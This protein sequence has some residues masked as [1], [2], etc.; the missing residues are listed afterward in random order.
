MKS[1]S[2]FQ[3]GLTAGTLLWLLC[4]GCA[5]TDTTATAAAA[6]T[7]VAVASVAPQG[8][9]PAPAAPQPAISPA[10]PIPSIVSPQVDEGASWAAIK[11][12]TFDQR[13]SF[14]SGAG[15]LESQLS[16]QV[17][18]LNA[19]RAALPSTVDT[20][21]WD[22]AMRDLV[23]SQEYLK[24]MVGEAGQSSPDTWDQEKDKVDQ[25]WQK[26]ED[27]FDKVRTATTF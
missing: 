21:D 8:L 25:A 5:K 22:F 23:V 11:D 26:A 4:A 12:F 19:K 20:K 10:V 27:A 13:A 6:P 24:S 18:Q 1:P 14:L 7:P 9:A 15:S 16:G 3:S 17:A 2:P